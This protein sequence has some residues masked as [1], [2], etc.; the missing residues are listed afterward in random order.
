MDTL[1]DLGKIQMLSLWQ[2]WSSLCLWK[3]PDGKAEKQIETRHWFTNYKGLIAIHATKTFTPEAKFEIE[4]NK[5][6]QNALE[7]H[8]YMPNIHGAKYLPSGAILGVVEL[9]KIVKMDAKNEWL[10]NYPE[11]EKHFG[12]YEA[13]R[14][15]WCLR[16]PIEFK[17]PIVCRG[18]Q[19]IGS[20]PAEVKA[21]IEKQL[22]VTV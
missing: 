9:Y 18:L 7:R 21:E 12:F 2:P 3:N 1:F 13:G 6:M 16:N 8:G 5:E 11:R 19:G 10:S 4:T 15:A 20:P 22:L 14:Y 17:T